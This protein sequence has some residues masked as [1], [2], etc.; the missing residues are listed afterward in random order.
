M[1]TF[2]A[3]VVRGD[4]PAEIEDWEDADLPAGNVTIDVTHCP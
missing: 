2:K 1:G 3:V 4:G